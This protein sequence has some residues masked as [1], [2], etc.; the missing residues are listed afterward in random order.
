M[1]ATTVTTTN[2]T[3]GPGSYFDAP[4]G[5]AEPATP[6]TAPGAGWRDVGG[7]QDGITLKVAEEWM[8]ITVDQ[9]VDTPERRRTKREMSIATNLAETTLENLALVQN[10][11]APAAAVAG[12]QTFEPTMG[13][14]AFSPAYRAAIHDGQGPS[15]LN[16]RIIIRKSLSTEGT[17]FAYQ[18]DG[19][20]VFSMTRVAHFVSGSIK[21]F[22]NLLQTA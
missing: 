18:K 14:A 22:S 15:G 10:E 11:A 5:T 16:H 6:T 7:T 1:T 4:F 9:L 12:V 20:R 17:E 21:P 3:S 13:L 19:Q 2:L 8:E